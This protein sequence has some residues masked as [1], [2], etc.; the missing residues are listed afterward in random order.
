MAAV[1][2]MR[3]ESN[4]SLKVAKKSKNEKGLLRSLKLANIR[5][6]LFLT[7]LRMLL[8]TVSS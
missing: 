1:S 6:L 4:A 2:R 5:D 3:F 8:D 7:V